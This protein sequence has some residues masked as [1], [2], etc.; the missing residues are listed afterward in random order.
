M[1]AGSLDAMTVRH[2]G[3]PANFYYGP[4]GIRQEPGPEWGSIRYTGFVYYGGA[5]LDLGFLAYAPLKALGVPRKLHSLSVLG[6]RVT[7]AGVAAFMD[8]HPRCQI[9][10]DPKE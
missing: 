2:Y 3:N 9:V 5:Y 6:T 1:S 10:A 8:A 7:K 4:K